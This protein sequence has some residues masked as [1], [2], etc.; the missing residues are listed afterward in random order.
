MREFQWYRTGVNKYNKLCLNATKCNYMLITNK[1]V[2]ADPSIF[3]DGV[4]LERAT[5]F[6]YLGIV[7]DEKLKF[8]GH[9]DK[10]RGKLSRLCGVSYRLGRHLN[11]A[12]AKKFYFACVYSVLVY[13]ICVWGGVLQCTSRANEIK[14][15]H[16]R[17]VKNLFKKYCSTQC[18]FV[19]MGL[20]KLPELHKL[21]IAIYMFK[22]LKLNLCPTLQVDLDIKY[23]EHNYQTRNADRLIPP[24]P[25]VE[26]IRMGYKYQCNEVWNSVPGNIKEETSLKNFK[27]SYKSFLMSIY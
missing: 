7:L 2:E 9:I 10:L 8:H 26:A 5:K 22:I 17:I 3:I 11:L 21:H 20:L 15:T 24:F 4:R 23:P 19:G 27:R 1:R 6:K 25:R 18:V 12:T 13:G 16:A 14:L